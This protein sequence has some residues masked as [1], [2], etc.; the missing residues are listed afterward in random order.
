MYACILCIL[1]VPRRAAVTLHHVV[2]IAA[3]SPEDQKN[4][5]A[6]NKWAMFKKSRADDFDAELFIDCQPV[7]HAFISYS[8][9]R[10]LLC[11]CVHATVR[12]DSVV[13]I[14]A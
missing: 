5:E 12:D 7:L 11:Q 4:Q 8:S 6:N 2:S 3:F 9:L 13:L 14:R 10:V 1:I